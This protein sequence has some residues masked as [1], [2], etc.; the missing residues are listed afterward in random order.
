MKNKPNHSEEIKKSYD[1]VK[2]DVKGKV[3]G[4]GREAVEDIEKNVDN[5]KHDAKIK[6]TERKEEL[7]EKIHNMK[8]DHSDSKK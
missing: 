1:N 3:N 2:H 6:M 4:E 8:K 7:Q 5:A